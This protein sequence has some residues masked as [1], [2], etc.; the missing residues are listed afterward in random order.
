M[1][2]VS[3]LNAHRRVCTQLSAVLNHWTIQWYPPSP[4]PPWGVGGCITAFRLSISFATAVEDEEQSQNPQRVSLTGIQKK[5]QEYRTLFQEKPTLRF[6]PSCVTHALHYYRIQLSNFPSSCGGALALVSPWKSLGRFV[7]SGRN[8]PTEESN[9]Y[10]PKKGYRNVS[11]ASP[12]P[13]ERYAVKG[14]R[15]VY[16]PASKVSALVSDT[17]PK[18]SFTLFTR[19]AS[20]FRSPRLFN[21]C[22]SFCRWLLYTITKI[23][24]IHTNGPS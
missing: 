15:A 16:S 2:T 11:I 24:R 20:A 19:S 10:P 6:R 21:F 12:L 23:S 8:L 22:L 3:R 18:S 9:S 7:R 4:P 1:S 14:W 13:E 5:R 17:N